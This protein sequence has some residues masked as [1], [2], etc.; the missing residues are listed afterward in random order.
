MCLKECDVIC[1]K[2][3]H[4]DWSDSEE[5]DSTRAAE[6]QVQEEQQQE[7]QIPD[8]QQEEQ[9]E[10]EEKKQAQQEDVSFT[11]PV[12]SSRPEGEDS[13]ETDAEEMERTRTRKSV[14]LF[15]N[16]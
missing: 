7:E 2:S 12:E 13:E 8:R 16:F 3:V 10:G 1:Y 15:D 14:S 6:L 4:D 11:S 9:Q 5:G